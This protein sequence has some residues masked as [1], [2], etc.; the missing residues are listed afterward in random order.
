MVSL[1]KHVVLTD[2]RLNAVYYFFI[3][4]LVS[5]FVYR[6]VSGQWWLME[7][8][9][10]GRVYPWPE[11]MRNR[12]NLEDVVA[13]KL[14]EP[15]CLEPDTYEYWWSEAWRF[16]PYSCLGLCSR[17]TTSRPPVS[18]GRSECMH[19]EEA[20]VREAS[21]QMFFVTEFSDGLLDQEGLERFY[22]TPVVEAL[23]LGF[24]Y[25]FDVSEQTAGDSFFSKTGDTSYASAVDTLTAVLDSKGRVVK[26]F[27]PPQPAGLTVSE[28]YALAEHAL[29]DIRPIAGRNY[30][31]NATGARLEGPAIRLAGMEVDIGISCYA[32]VD[33]APADIDVG[34]DGPACTVSVNPTATGWTEREHLDIVDSQGSLRSRRL[35]GLRVR[36]NVGGSY[37]FWNPNAVLLNILSFIVFMSLPNMVLKFFC[38]HCLGHLSVLYTSAIYERFDLVQQTAGMAARLMSMKTAFHELEDAHGEGEKP[39][40]SRRR[41]REHLFDVMRYR[42]DVLDAHELG[43]FADCCFNTLVM[44]H[45]K[46]SSMRHLDGGVMQ[47]VSGVWRRISRFISSVSSTTKPVHAT[48]RI[49][50][51]GF[52]VS[53]SSLERFTIDDCMLLFGTDRKLGILENFFL[54][55]NIRACVHPKGN[56]G[57]VVSASG[58]LLTPSQSLSSAC[59]SPASP[60]G[61]LSGV[62]SHSAVS[63]SSARQ[64]GHTSRFDVRIK[65]LEA[66]L[67]ETRAEAAVQAEALLAVWHLARNIS[68]IVRAAPSPESQRPF[69]SETP[70]AEPVLH[71][72]DTPVDTVDG[73]GWRSMGGDT[74]SEGPKALLSVKSEHGRT[75]PIMC[76][77]SDTV[78]DLKELMWA[79]SGADMD[80]QHFFYKGEELKHGQVLQDQIPLSTSDA[81]LNWIVTRRAATEN[82]SASHCGMNMAAMASARAAGDTLTRPTL[83][84]KAVGGQTYEV[85]W[86][87]EESVQGLRERVLELT[88]LPLETMQVVV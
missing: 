25:I 33:A 88:G 28:I 21:D 43:Y 13:D 67:D 24:E 48:D 49:T 17:G 3:A 35:H 84:V 2:A 44:S 15:F 77:A 39:G 62:A 70:S 16:G 23:A 81:V 8:V 14:R 79:F 30:W 61:G 54:P 40:I 52:S 38:S 9:P 66:A 53:H 32:G 4:V 76:K 59:R 22:F 7:V 20:Y 68:V 55:G 36:F 57:L 47:Q 5:V 72:S 73:H 75:Y 74:M 78:D 26:V 31:P 11:G 10:K 29:D 34:W 19:P 63:A 65:L 46:V 64:S 27:K 71:A 69:S 18:Q 86:D 6:F 82:P 12:A 45:K 41:A 83:K 50:I 37:K 58:K 1:P 80:A 60:E 87:A 51:D 85:P 42:K 56:L